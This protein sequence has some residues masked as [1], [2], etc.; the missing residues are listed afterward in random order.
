VKFPRI[1]P[2]LLACIALSGCATR[3]TKFRA[4][5]PRGGLIAEWTARGFYY[6]T[7]GGYRITAVER[8][9]APPHS[10]LSKYPN[11][12]RV[13]ATGPHIVHWSTTKPAW[14]EK[15]EGKYQREDLE[16]EVGGDWSESQ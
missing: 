10:V 5:D 2:A 7:E 6:R 14:L 12:R 13:T 15:R 4:T 16:E 9:S 3:Y 8:L 11:G 1:I